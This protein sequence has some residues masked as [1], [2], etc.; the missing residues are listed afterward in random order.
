MWEKSTGKLVRRMKADSMFLNSVAVHPYF[1][2][3]ACS[4]IDSSVKI[5]E[6]ELGDSLDTSHEIERKIYTSVFGCQMFTISEAKAAIEKANQLKEL[7]NKAFRANNTNEAIDF[8]KR[9]LHKLDFHP[10]GIKYH[11]SRLQLKML[12]HLNL[13]ATYI[14]EKEWKKAIKETSIV[15]EIN[16]DNIKALYRRAKSYFRLKLFRESRNDIKKALKLDPSDNAIQSLAQKLERIP[17][18]AGKNEM[19]SGIFL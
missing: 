13:A 11:Q 12:T 1:P 15:L 5:F 8:Y 17:D 18:S 14:A 6:V 4:G 3:I 2:K 9:T 16:P 19:F 7:G 10:P